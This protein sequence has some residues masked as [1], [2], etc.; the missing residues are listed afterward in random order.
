M[1]R[2]TFLFLAY[3]LIWTVLF[4]FL[5]NIARKISSLKRQVDL[6]QDALGNQSK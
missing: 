6:L 1:N 3:A 5:C 2:L 4:V